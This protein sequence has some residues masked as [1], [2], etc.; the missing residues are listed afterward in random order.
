MAHER[1]S[2]GPHPDGI[3]ERTGSAWRAAGA[4]VPRRLSDE[5][6]RYPE[7]GRDDPAIAQ[8]R[9]AVRGRADIPAALETGDG[10][11]ATGEICRGTDRPR[12]T[13]LYQSDPGQAG[14]DR[15]RLSRTC[16]FR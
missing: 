5:A 15:K 7:A 10:S 14:R 12:A 3:G 11:A 2:P 1:P 13:R 8:D 9:M 6:D 16:R 4:A